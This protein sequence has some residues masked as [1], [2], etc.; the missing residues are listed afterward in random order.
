MSLDVYLKATRCVTVFDYNITHN[1]NTMAVAVELY[2]PLWRPE[3][4]GVTKASELVPY[5]EQGLARLTQGGREKYAQYE[6]DNGWG[7]YEN[8]VDFVTSYLKACRD[9]PDAQIEISR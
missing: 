2:L 7:R 9:D 6:A 8:L 5:L 1:L 3:E 4:L